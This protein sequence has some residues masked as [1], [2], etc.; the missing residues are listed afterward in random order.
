MER[1]GIIVPRAVMV[2]RRRRDDDRHDVEAQ[3]TALQQARLPAR[4]DVEAVQ[5]RSVP[6]RRAV[7]KRRFEPAGGAVQGRPQ[8]EQRQAHHDR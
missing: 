4:H 1:H 8:H 3:V 2:Q 7:L 6:A 5:A